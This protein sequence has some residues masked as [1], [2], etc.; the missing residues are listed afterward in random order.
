[1]TSNLRTPLGVG[2][3]QWLQFWSKPEWLVKQGRN[4]VCMT[5][6]LPSR[7]QTARSSCVFKQVCIAE[8]CRLGN[9]ITSDSW[10]EDT[11]SFF[12][13]QSLAMLLHQV[14]I[15]L[16]L[17]AGKVSSCPRWHSGRADGCTLIV[18]PQKTGTNL[19]IP[20]F[21]NFLMVQQL[22]L[23]REHLF[24]STNCY[25]LPHSGVS[26]HTKRSS[27]TSQPHT[28]FSLSL[29][30]TL[31][32]SLSSILQGHCHCCR[33]TEPHSKLD[34]YQLHVGYSRLKLELRWFTL[35]CQYCKCS[36]TVLPSCWLLFFFS[37]T[38]EVGELAFANF[39]RK[40]K[41]LWI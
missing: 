8:H 5:A 18:T 7:R 10:K 37:L 41:L 33:D 1:M 3:A 20:V 38:K 40:Q 14:E 26:R 9:M 30:V 22:L 21:L 2:D 17:T 11:W 39:N 29:S 32:V 31:S 12:N 36:R 35:V 34:T 25:L 15:G 6:L 23:E 13:F 24:H 4:W 27:T 19:P 16:A 28:I